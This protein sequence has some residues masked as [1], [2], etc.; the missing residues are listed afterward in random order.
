MFLQEIS[1]YVTERRHATVHYHVLYVKLNPLNGEGDSIGDI[2][3]KGIYRTLLLTVSE[4]S[5][6]DG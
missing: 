4:D 3:G 1:S 6:V 5:L 2:R